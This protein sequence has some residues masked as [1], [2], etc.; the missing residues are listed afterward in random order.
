VQKK[1]AKFVNHKTYQSGKP[2]RIVKDS[3]HLRPLQSVF[4]K[5]G[6]ESCR[7]QVTRTMLSERRWTWSKY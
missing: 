1:A 3:A 6:I 2:R 4:R 5:T 7:G